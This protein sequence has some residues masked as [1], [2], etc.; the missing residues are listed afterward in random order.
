M[1]DGL[2]LVLLPVLQFATI[3]EQDDQLKAPQNIFPCHISY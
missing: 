2:D 1:N 3:W